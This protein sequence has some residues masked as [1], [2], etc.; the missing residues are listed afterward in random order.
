MA[1]WYFAGG[2]LSD[3][4]NY[5]GGPAGEL[6]QSGDIVIGQNG[7]INSVVDATGGSL[8]VATASLLNIDTGASLTAVTAQETLLWEAQ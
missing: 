1:T 2:S 8:T 7:G 3:P 6:P 4:N 5:A